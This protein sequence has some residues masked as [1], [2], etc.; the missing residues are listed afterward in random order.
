MKVNLKDCI[1]SRYRGIPSKNIVFNKEELELAQIIE[2]D[3]I[4][5]F[6]LKQWEN[7]VNIAYDNPRIRAMLY[8]SYRT[9]SNFIQNLLSR[10]T[11]PQ[12][13][14]LVLK[15][16]NVTQQEFDLAMTKTND[17]I[18]HDKFKKMDSILLDGKS[19]KDY[20]SPKSMSYM[21]YYML[22]SNE[23]KYDGLP[24][25]FISVLPN[26]EEWFKRF[27]D[28]ENIMTHIA[29]N[30]KLPD[31]IR[32]RAYRYGIVMNDID[33]DL[34]AE[35]CEDIYQSCVQTYTDEEYDTDKLNVMSSGQMLCELLL[36]SKF[37][38]SCQKDLLYRTR[39]MRDKQ[40]TADV[41]DFLSLN[42][43]SQSIILEMLKNPHAFPTHLILSNKNTPEFVKFK[44]GQRLVKQ[45]INS[46]SPQLQCSTKMEL[47]DIAKTSE[48][49]KEDYLKLIKLG[50]PV[51]NI[52]II[53][54]PK[55]QANIACGDF[56]SVSY[57]KT[58][59][60]RLF[61]DV[62]KL[63]F[64]E[65][66]FTEEQYVKFTD[67]LIQELVSSDFLPIHDFDNLLD[68]YALK[69]QTDHYATK[70]LSDKDFELFIQCIEK[71]EKNKKLMFEEI[72]NNSK[73]LLDALEGYKEKLTL[74]YK[75]DKAFKD[76]NDLVVKNTDELKDLFYLTQTDDGHNLTYFINL[77]VLANCKNLDT[78]TEQVYEILKNN[79]SQ[80]T[81]ICLENHIV[82]EM[83]NDYENEDIIGFANKFQNTEKFVEIIENLKEQYKEKEK[84]YDT[85]FY[86][87]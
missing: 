65:A 22:L 82:T 19:P 83:I 60:E 54:S 64:K 15:R 21:T 78:I 32:N 62:A 52:G 72:A 46:L 12:L 85:P 6:D 50:D 7:I 53:S 68:G 63:Y 77:N 39:N 36:Q 61:I 84:T 23:I 24:L 20:F 5:H 73:T 18:I 26:Y 76:V 11:D 80:Q 30:I 10:E 1:T 29:L 56:L 59:L 48:F 16:Q 74:Q 86:E 66:M 45:D 38:E 42:T 55:T 35:M 47:L 79:V 69:M 17:K 9:P 8:S 58:P 40:D 81:L 4:C 34:T 67:G 2:N 33:T 31:D 37:P 71:I 41:R 44:M 28:N 27:S 51:F 13:A 3:D 14:S 57:I 87:R 43:T 75:S 70:N 49:K 25:K